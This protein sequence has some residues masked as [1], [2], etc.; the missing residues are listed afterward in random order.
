MFL[1]YD[2]R[3]HT[4]VFNPTLDLHA[5]QPLAFLAHGAILPI[6]RG[7]PGPPKAHHDKPNNAFTKYGAPKSVHWIVR[8][9]PEGASRPDGSVKVEGKKRIKK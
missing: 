2:H 6:A 1:Y 3:H 5:P 9:H 4:W 8:E 7:P